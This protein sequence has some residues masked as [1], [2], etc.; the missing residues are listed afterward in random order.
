M[1]NQDDKDLKYDD[2][3]KKMH[4]VILK[5]EHKIDKMLQKCLHGIK[6]MAKYH[7]ITYKKENRGTSQ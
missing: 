6:N 1:L 3:L 2:D 5:K 4:Q 7:T